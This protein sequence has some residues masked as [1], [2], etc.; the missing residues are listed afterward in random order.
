MIQLSIYDI[1]ESDLDEM[2]MKNIEIVIAQTGCARDK[3]ETLLK[4]HDND[5]VSTV[6]ELSD[7]SMDLEDSNNNDNDNNND[8]SSSS[9]SFS[10][11]TPQATTTATA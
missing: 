11:P 1:S 8:L 6:L 5:I 4:R 10:P 3:A 9:I 2:Y 7:E